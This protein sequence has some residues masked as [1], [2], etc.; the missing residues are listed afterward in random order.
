MGAT[1]RWRATLTLVLGVM[2]LGIFWTALHPSQAFFFRDFLAGILPPA[3]LR[4]RAFHQGVWPLWFPDLFAGFPF[5]SDLASQPFYPLTLLYAISP[6]NLGV[7][8]FIIVHHLIATAGMY[9]WVRRLSGGGTWS[10]LVAGAAF[11]LS[12]FSV[13]LENVIFYLCAYAWAPWALWVVEDLVARVAWAS[14]AWL[15]VFL[16]LCLVAGDPQ[17]LVVVGGLALLRVTC[18]WAGR[19]AAFLKGLLALALSGA[20]A[21]GLSA[22][23]LLPAL[24]LLRVS[25]R[26]E[27]VTFDSANEWALHPL[28]TMEW[29]LPGAFGD[30]FP[31][32]TF[33]GRALI[34]GP[35]IYPYYLSLYCCAVVVLLTPLGLRGLAPRS[36]WFFGLGGGLLL[37]L[38][39]G[40]YVGLYGL[41]T[42]YF[43]LWSV[44]RY[45]E[46]LSA[47]VLLLLCA[48]GGVGLENFFQKSCARYLA[49]VSAVSL[50]AA[51]G[52]ALFREPIAVFISKACHQAV[53]PV[54]VVSI[55]VKLLSLGALVAGILILRRFVR[56]SLSVPLIG[57]LL[58]TDISV[59]A[60]RRVW[61]LPLSELLV[62]PPV[63]FQPHER[64]F[65]HAAP[66]VF[67]PGD[68]TPYEWQRA[69]YE[70]GTW[71][72][73]AGV[74]AGADYFAAY[75]SNLP[76]EFR[77]LWRTFPSET[78]FRLWDVHWVLVSPEEYRGGLDR[79]SHLKPVGMLNGNH[80]LEVV[81]RFPR[82]WLV[83]QWIPLQTKGDLRSAF[84]PVETLK[85]LALVDPPTAN[86]LNAVRPSPPGVTT[87]ASVSCVTPNPNTKRC[88]VATGATSILVMSDAYLNGWKAT[89]DGL[90]VPVFRVN[91]YM[92]G[93]AVGAGVHQV[94]LRYAPKSVRQGAWISSMTLLGL[95]LVAAVRRLKSRRTVA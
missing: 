27:Q 46:R 56:P 70:A 86:L 26:R 78:L 44:F 71:L 45:P 77:K 38:S 55:A 22:L 52:V 64:I 57:L 69:R 91:L 93:V 37:C 76:A 47:F 51:G 21:L 79:F 90:S 5:A 10:A 59:E 63:P 72:P 81:N 1:W 42:R 30:F 9:L 74:L 73:N 25:E 11:G 49:P 36:R 65:S 67:D 40:P 83:Q 8:V 84:E 60:H 19:H 23:A 15:S 34:N 53:S 87:E 24:D 94:V 31:D 29:L 85:T 32:R 17:T 43:P 48:L 20:I 13:S 95:I 18:H 66:F 16:A 68:S 35:F 50:V 54:L 41:F 4:S 7:T 88:S 89:V 62:T 80:L 82:E 3:M 6:W 33:F 92:R 61:T 58:L 12:A 28:R 75:G 2:V 39:L 14:V